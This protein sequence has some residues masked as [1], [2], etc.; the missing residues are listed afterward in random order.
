MD[1][2]CSLCL[3][4]V[5]ARSFIGIVLGFCFFFLNEPFASIVAVAGIAYFNPIETL[6]EAKIAPVTAGIEKLVM[7]SESKYYNLFLQR[8]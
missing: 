6:G 1:G 8:N 7:K 4:K 2:M 3:F 5:S